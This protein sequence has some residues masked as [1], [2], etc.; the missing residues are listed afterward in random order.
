MYVNGLA[1]LHLNAPMSYMSRHTY[2]TSYINV[3]D[4]TIPGILF[5]I[6]TNRI[7]FTI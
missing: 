1:P 6:S 5:I 7:S 3:T 4:I 2:T